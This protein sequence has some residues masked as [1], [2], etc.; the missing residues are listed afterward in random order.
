MAHGRGEFAAK[1]FIKY[2]LIGMC[3]S[4]MSF[5]AFNAIFCFSKFGRMDVDHLYYVYQFL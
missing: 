1:V 5:V 4:G 3:A 2:S